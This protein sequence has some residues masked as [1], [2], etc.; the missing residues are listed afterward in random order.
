MASPLRKIM[1]T[2]KGDESPRG[3]M[4]LPRGKK[5]ILKILRRASFSNKKKN[6]TQSPSHED[7][8]PV[9]RPILRKTQQAQD[10]EDLERLHKELRSAARYFCLVIERK[11]MD[12]IMAKI[13]DNAAIV[14]DSVISIDDVLTTCIRLQKINRDLVPYRKAVHKCIGDLVRWTDQLLVRGNVK[15]DLKEGVEFVGAI[16]RSVQELMD[17]A[18]PRLRKLEL[19]EEIRNSIFLFEGSSENILVGREHAEEQHVWNRRDSGISEDSGAADVRDSPPPKSPLPRALRDSGRGSYNCILDVNN[20]HI[21]QSDSYFHAQDKYLSPPMARQGR[22]LTLS[23]RTSKESELSSFSSEDFRSPMVSPNGSQEFNRPAFYSARSSIDGS[24]YSADEMDNHDNDVI[25]ATFVGVVEN[26]ETAP[27]PRKKKSFQVYIELLGGYHKPSDDILKRPTSAF[28]G[29][30]ES[31]RRSISHSS[32]STALH[33]LSHHGHH[34]TPTHHQNGKMENHAFSSPHLPTASPR[35]THIDWNQNNRSQETPKKKLLS[36]VEEGSG[37]SRK[38]SNVSSVSS[39]SISSTD[40]DESTPALDCLDVSRFLVHR[41]DGQGNMLIGGAI[42]ALI[43][44]ASGASKNDIIFYEAFL[45][46]YRTFISPK[47]LINKLLYRERRFRE[48]AHKKASQSAFFLLLRVV[49]ELNGKVERSILEQLMKEVYRLIC[50]GDLYV[51]KILRNK[52]LPKCDNYY[53]RSRSPSSPISPLPTTPLP[54]TG[55][56]ILDFHSEELAQQ[57]TMIDAANFGAIEIPEILAWGKEQSEANSPNLAVFTDH[58]NKVSYWSRSYLLS[59]E[60]QQD[61]E[62][63]YLKFLKIM[64]HLRRFNNFNSFLAVLSAMDCSAVRRLEWPKQYLDQLAEYTYLIDSS[65]SFRAY[66]MAL[67]EAT[68]PCIPY[69]GLILQDVTFVCLG[70]VDELP[71]GKVNFVKRWQ[72]F[73]ILDTFRRFKLMQYDFEVKEDIRQFFGGFNNYLNEDDLF[74]KSLKLKPRSG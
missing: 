66:R 56:T 32:S 19:Q 30:E 11:N 39:S 64:K 33:T 36:L 61:R 71:D 68:P 65:A 50:N 13:P 54:K 25:P 62:K 74:D 51:G 23:S 16:E 73:N 15:G 6:S 40:E 59:F 31:F 58:F 72:L 53:N 63:V 57:L 48:R 70:N 20:G 17:T 14:L 4:T 26:H 35:E 67:L 8:E 49:D 9:R 38:S 47:D 21:G 29:Y 1:G 3:T 41:D 45:T 46:T 18:I 22:H 24:F 34:L 2:H 42:D 43:V 28:D 5:K 69:L 10:L 37:G 44:H 52:M 27:V 7:I 12:I 60:K 55:C